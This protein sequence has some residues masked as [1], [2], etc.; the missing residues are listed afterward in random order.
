MAGLILRD[1]FKTYEGTTVLHGIG[2]DVQDGEF[3]VFV[4]PSGCGK[5]TTLRLIAGL[6]DASGGTIEIGGRVVNNLEPKDRDIAMVFQNYAIY[7]HM[8]VRKNI[9][10]GLRTAKMSKDAKEQ[11]IQ[12]VAGIL[13][14]T[15]LL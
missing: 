14:M 6:E 10:F 12:E 3:V 7:P 5:S 15:D 1:L 8:T 2:L 4:G 11:R 9:A 13:D